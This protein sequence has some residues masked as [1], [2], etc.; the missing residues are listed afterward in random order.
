LDEHF[1][2]LYTWFAALGG[3]LSF[4]YQDYFTIKK[5]HR[6]INLFIIIQILPVLSMLDRLHILYYKRIMNKIQSLAKRSGIKNQNQLRLALI[7][8]GVSEATSRDIWIGG[9]NTKKHYAVIVALE[10]L[11]Q[12][13]AEKFL[14]DPEN[15]SYPKK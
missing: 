3:S 4:L 1:I 7:P 2:F 12:I 15:V 10:N 8:F 14:E 13:P 11:F 9:A 6:H 5:L